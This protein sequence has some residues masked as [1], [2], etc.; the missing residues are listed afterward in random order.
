[1]SNTKT[2]AIIYATKMRALHLSSV[3][4]NYKTSDTHGRNYNYSAVSRFLAK[5]I[6]TQE[7][8]GEMSK[9][10]GLVT[11]NLIGICDEAEGWVYRQLTPSFW[12]NKKYHAIAKVGLPDVDETVE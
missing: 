8:H 3:L 6:E 2:Q 10:A 12:K 1:M 4:E 5:L 11:E 9:E 7:E